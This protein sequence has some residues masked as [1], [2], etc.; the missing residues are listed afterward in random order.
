V[1]RYLLIKMDIVCPICHR[2]D[3]TPGLKLMFS[4]CG[5]Q[6]CEDCMRQ[7][8]RTDPQII[9]PLCR[10]ALKRGDFS[11]KYIEEREV[12]REKAIRSEVLAV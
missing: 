5:H 11:S 1:Q 6:L 7:M 8:F 2:D 4:K 12:E 9:C 3:L 10:T